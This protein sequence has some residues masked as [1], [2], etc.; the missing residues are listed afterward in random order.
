MALTAYCRWLQVAD[1]NSMD[2]YNEWITQTGLNVVCCFLQER[3]FDTAIFT[4]AHSTLF[5][6][7]FCRMSRIRKRQKYEAK[8]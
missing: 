6:S 8:C 2:R 7:K 4:S 5:V 3:W 1:Y